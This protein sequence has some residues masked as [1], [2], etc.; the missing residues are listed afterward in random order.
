[1]DYIIHA[2]EIPKKWTFTYNI[3]IVIISSVASVS[4]DSSSTHII[5]I[6][7]YSTLWRVVW[8][9]F[10]TFLFWFWFVFY[11]WN[12][13]TRY[14]FSLFCSHTFWA[15]FIQDSLKC[16][17]TQ[18][19]LL[20]YKCVYTHVLTRHDIELAA[21]IYFIFLFCSV[22]FCFICRRHFHMPLLN[23]SIQLSS[24]SFVSCVCLLTLPL[25]L[26]LWYRFSVYVS[27]L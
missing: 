16:C 25:Q 15:S 6:H 3:C 11:L 5:I 4:S 20:G 7:V 13:L 27:L 1:M 10:H 2:D 19:C 8:I 9:I 18:V 22:L 23:D 12:S 17:R 14:R 21:S 24:S 26:F